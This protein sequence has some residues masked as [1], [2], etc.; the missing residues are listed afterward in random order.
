MSTNDSAFAYQNYTAVGASPVGQVVALYDVILRDF[1]R[2]IAAVAA[3]RI[4]KRVEA[5][6]HALVVIGELQGVL[7]FKR[8]GEPAR[9]L[10]I[11]YKVARS[12]VT[13]ASILNSQEAFEELVAMFAR[14]R[15]AWS[16]IER[17]IP[18]SEP[19][20][21]P[22]LASEAQ[23]QAGGMKNDPDPAP[24]QHREDSGGSRWSA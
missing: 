2:A 22:R 13:R 8:G 12:M 9:N 17:A 14:V 16:Q 11:F 19:A 1:R 18:C 10:D 23:T 5:V 20:T 3:G 21:I 15:T 24:P 7:D 6:N 4:E